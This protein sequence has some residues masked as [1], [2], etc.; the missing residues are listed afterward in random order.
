[1]DRVDNPD[2]WLRCPECGS[3]AEVDNLSPYSDYRAIVRCTADD[4]GAGGFF[5]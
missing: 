5:E 1:M 4:C 2:G 3:D